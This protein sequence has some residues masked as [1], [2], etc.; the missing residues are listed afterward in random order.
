MIEVL[1]LLWARD[2]KNQGGCLCGHFERCDY[3]T[4]PYSEI[5]EAYRAIP[6]HI[7]QMARDY[8]A[9]PPQPH[10]LGDEI[11]NIFNNKMYEKAKES[12]FK[13]WNS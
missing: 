8:A 3:C 11:V 9:I 1:K 5:G 13:L 10:P 4:F 6:E 12:R 2:K 7:K